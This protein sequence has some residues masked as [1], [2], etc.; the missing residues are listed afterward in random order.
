MEA[1]KEKLIGIADVEPSDKELMDLVVRG[2]QSAF[3][4]L[5][6]RHSIHLFSMARRI[7]GD[8]GSAEELLQDAFFQLWQKASRFDLTR[9]S[10]IGWLLTITRNRALSRLR[11]NKHRFSEPFLDEVTLT[12]NL[13]ILDQQIANEQVATALA[14]LP[15]AQ[16]EVITLAYFS[17]LTCV[18]IAVRMCA[19]LGTTKTR[20]RSALKTMKKTLSEP[21]A[22]AQETPPRNTTPFPQFATQFPQ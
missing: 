19:P 16:L 2:D 17:G 11:R 7:T 9:G 18:E 13:S 22:A 6:D 5:Y 1:V 20:L 15:T 21:S 12:K 4:V 8:S 14:T 10:L 3:E